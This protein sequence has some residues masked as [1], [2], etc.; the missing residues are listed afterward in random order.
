VEGL[1]SPDED[2][3][4]EF[5]ENPSCRCG[6]RGSVPWLAA[7]ATP[8]VVRVKW[9]AATESFNIVDEINCWRSGSDDWPR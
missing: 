3:I 4:V 9:E 2:E 5:H 7:D 6:S 1:E 8:M